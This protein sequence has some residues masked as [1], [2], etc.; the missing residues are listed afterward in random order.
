[1]GIESALQSGMQVMVSLEAV[2]ERF[3][4]KA[5]SLSSPLWLLVYYKLVSNGPRFIQ[6]KFAAGQFHDSSSPSPVEQFP[7]ITLI[8]HRRA[9]GSLNR[10]AP[11]TGGRA[12]SMSLFDRYVCDDF[13][14]AKYLNLGVLRARR[15][16]IIP[17]SFPDQDIRP[18]SGLLN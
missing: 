7:A 4:R 18:N 1:M 13:V 15:D 5:N 12:A 14:S 2:G 3:G 16:F 10:S 6:S 11:K 9:C 17:D 8:V